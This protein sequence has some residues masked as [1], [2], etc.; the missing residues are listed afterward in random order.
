MI[1]SPGMLMAYSV[2]KDSTDLKPVTIGGQII[3]GGGEVLSIREANGLLE[4]ATADIFIEVGRFRIPLK[5]QANGKVFLTKWLEKEE[6]ILLKNPEQLSG[7]TVYLT[8]FAPQ[9]TAPDRN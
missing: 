5:E 6:E 7:I 4:P 3:T 1:V 9:I 2:T 8:L